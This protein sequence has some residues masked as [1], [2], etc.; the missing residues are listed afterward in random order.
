ME[1]LCETPQDHDSTSTSS[2]CLTSRDSPLMSPIFAKMSAAITIA[3]SY[4]LTS[5]VPSSLDPFAIDS[6]GGRRIVAILP[7]GRVR[8]VNHRVTVVRDDGVVEDDGADLPP[9]L[10]SAAQTE[11]R[12]R[13]L[14][15]VGDL[16]VE[17]E[18][19]LGRR[20]AL[21][22]DLGHDFVADVEVGPGDHR[23]AFGDEQPHEL[24]CSRRLTGGLPKFRNRIELAE[25]ALLIDPAED[26]GDCDQD[27]CG[28]CAAGARDIWRVP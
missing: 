22:E 23:L 21:I 16:D 7:P 6:R 2:L 18:R 8:K 15:L 20:I 17:R 24:R 26:R 3:P 10:E 14:A 13:R 19:A 28:G 9:V 27:R 4:V 5:F 1:A 11:R 12:A 25:G